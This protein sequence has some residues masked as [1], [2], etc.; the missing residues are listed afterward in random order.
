[1]GYGEVRGTSDHYSDV[2]GRRKKKSIEGI[3]SCSSF[4]SPSRA[5][6]RSPVRPERLSIPALRS[7]RHHK[8]A[9]PSSLNPNGS[10]SCVPSQWGW[11]AS[12]NPNGSLSLESDWSFRCQLIIIRS[13]SG[14][15]LFKTYTDLT[16][17]NDPSTILVFPSAPSGIL[18]RDYAGWGFKT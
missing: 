14:S 17:E 4:R 5:C 7:L 13:K 10:L 11:C 16:K 6:L 18:L 2:D 15:W 12:L 9:L 1:M 8:H 3:C